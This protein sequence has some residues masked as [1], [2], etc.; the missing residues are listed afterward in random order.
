MQIR[1]LGGA[2]EVGRISIAVESKKTKVFVAHVE[3]DNCK[4]LTNWAKSELGLKA[5]APKTG[6]TFKV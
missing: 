6:Q 2:R 1:F 3:E 4:L 5:V